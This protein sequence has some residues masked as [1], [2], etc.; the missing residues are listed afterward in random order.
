MASVAVADSIVLDNK[1]N[2]PVKDKPGKMAVQWA[3]SVETTQKANKTIFKGSTLDLSSLAMI[4]QKGQIQLSSPNY[5]RY[6]RVVVW[7]TGKQ[8]PDLLTNWV[9][10]VSNKTFI[11][12]QDQLVPTV[13][14]AGAGC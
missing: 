12:N 1:T 2:Y 11:L 8:K 4:S 14:M 10:I 13:L 3:A 9:A 6:F 5:A 7:S